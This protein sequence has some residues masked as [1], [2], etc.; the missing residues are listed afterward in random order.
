M[1][2][3]CFVLRCSQADDRN[4]RWISVSTLE[5]HAHLLSALG[6]ALKNMAPQSSVVAA[7][8]NTLG[9]W[10]QVCQRSRRQHQQQ[11]QQAGE[12]VAEGV[13]AVAS[14]VMGALT[15]II[16]STDARGVVG[17]SLFPQMCVLAT[18]SIDLLLRRRLVRPPPRLGSHSHSPPHLA[19]T[20]PSQSGVDRGLDFCALGTSL[21]RSVAEHLLR[22][23]P[24]HATAETE[25]G[26]FQT[27]GKEESACETI[28]SGGGSGS[29]SD[30]DDWD[31][32][33][34]AA[35]DPRGAS[36]PNALPAGGRRNSAPRTKK[37]PDGV[38]L[39]A[40][41]CATA[42]LVRSAAGLFAAATASS[43]SSVAE[44]GGGRVS[45]VFASATMPKPSS[46]E[47][48]EEEK[49]E[50]HQANA[51]LAPALRCAEVVADTGSAGEGQ[52]GGL[53]QR[54][55]AKAVGIGC[56]LFEMRHVSP[57]FEEAIAGLVPEHRQ[58]LLRVLAF[59]A[60][61][62]SPEF[63]GTRAATVN[64]PSS[65]RGG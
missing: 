14:A 30:W 7:D 32:D 57:N 51:A 45:S 62:M 64:E 42:T 15:R 9:Q 29:G 55:D 11:H 23:Y 2:Q 53:R 8:E 46:K 25:E 44:T 49:R 28:R 65:V 33:D 41:F 26:G 19:G 60:A 6:I 43:S 47:E 12:V 38:R 18:R 10:G 4:V 36:V 31:D 40:A 34:D 22:W 63:T 54:G 16:T 56:S 5:A 50:R 24:E 58:V 35:T 20:R 39:K 59:E 37:N 17:A 52:A 27:K 61:A 48:G 1:T 13:A 21:L 3:T